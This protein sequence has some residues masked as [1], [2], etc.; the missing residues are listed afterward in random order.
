[1]KR[2]G[3]RHLSALFFSLVVI[4]SAAPPV[5]AAGRQLISFYEQGARDTADL[6]EESNLV[7]HY[8]ARAKA[9]STGN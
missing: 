9:R 1:M 2:F 8:G 4:W 5:A 7:D 6:F 3:D